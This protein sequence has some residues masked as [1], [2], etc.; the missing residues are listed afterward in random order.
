MVS[1]R[2]LTFDPQAVDGPS[3]ETQ[4]GLFPS[5]QRSSAE[6]GPQVRGDDYAF[7]RSTA[8]PPQAGSSDT[9]KV[10]DLFAGAGGLSLGV[11]EACAQLGLGFLATWAVD[12]DESAL[13]CYQ[14]NFPTERTSSDPLE[15]SLSFRLGSTLSEGERALAQDSGEIDL[16][17]GGPPCQGHSDLNNSTRRDD[18]K[19]SLYVLMARAAEVFEPEHILVENVIGARHDKNKAVQR[20][21]AHLDRLGYMTSLGTVDMSVIGVPQSRRRLILLA[22]RTIQPS[23]AGIEARYRAERRTVHWAIADLRGRAGSGGILD[24]PSIPSPDN[25]RRIDFLFEKDLRN[26]PDEMRPA[27]HRNKRHSYKS[28]YG[29][30]S[31]DEPAQTVTR[32]FYSTCMGRYV[33]PSER[34][35]L[36]AHEAARLQFFPDGF[37]FSPAGNR[38]ALARIIGN[39]VPMKLSFAVAHDLFTNLQGSE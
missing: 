15:L 34:R 31:W 12:S 27:C 39:A 24:E 25:Q 5:T 16:L 8:P 14:A 20:T 19:N 17:L 30:L 22:S 21:Q 18:P 6:A 10:I 35:T 29:R 13:R 37:D 33:H 1:S 36:T 11:R 2:L 4:L 28:V 3:T 26:L 9:V 7:L 38:T 23:I 32:G